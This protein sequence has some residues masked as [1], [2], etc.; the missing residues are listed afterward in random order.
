MKRLFIIFLFPLLFLTCH[1]GGVPSVKI[2]TNQPAIVPLLPPMKNQPKNIILMIGD[3]MGLSQI[4]AAMFMNNNKL[5][6]QRMPI[7]GLQ[8]TYSS[9]N[10]VTDSAAAATAFA[11]GV[12]TYNGAIGL[13]WKGD[14]RKT[15]L[16]EAEENGLATGMIATSTI[17]HAT[18]AAFIAHQKLRG[19]YEP[20]AADFLKTDID[21]FVGGGKKYFDRR[22]SDD[23]N[24]IDE[25]KD[26]GYQIENYFTEPDLTKIK[27]H[28][29][30]NFG[31][32]TSDDDPLTV[33]AG[34]DYLFA[35]TKV[36]INF[37]KQKS[38]KGFFMM[39]EGSQ[40]DWG[41]H[42]NNQEYVITELLD[43]D[44]AV[45][46]VLEFAEKDGETLVI[47]TADHETGGM[48]VGPG[49]KMNRVKTTF[50]TGKHSAAMVP[51]FSYGPGAEI[52]GG[53]YENKQIFHKMKR[54]FGF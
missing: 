29:E 41:G 5:N 15:I 39:I 11:C 1:K 43:F 26:K 4:S 49:S 10:L 14:P 51:V 50:T 7:I 35:A 40:I 30:K 23:R 17:V 42:A 37:L 22:D 28:S 47:V 12:K 34:R 53:V 8:K 31:Y 44:K 21:Y 52:F 18:P 16:E 6:I 54:A 32:F 20:I 46:E 3:G 33:N 24:L 9:D 25:L 13:D 2:A 19:F 48:A 27:I 45:G 36:G 38:D